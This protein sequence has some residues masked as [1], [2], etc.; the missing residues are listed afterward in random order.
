MGAGRRE[1]EGGKSGEG[2]FR[3]VRAG[4]GPLEHERVRPLHTS[5]WSAPGLG[6]A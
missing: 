2:A 6:S 1:H 4:E 3:A 5:T